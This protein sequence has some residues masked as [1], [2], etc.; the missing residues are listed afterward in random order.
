[1][2]IDG[3]E[4]EVNNDDDDEIAGRLQTPIFSSRRRW[5]WKHQRFSCRM[6]RSVEHESAGQ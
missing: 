5:W 2:G 3:D 1:M 4:M 6:Q